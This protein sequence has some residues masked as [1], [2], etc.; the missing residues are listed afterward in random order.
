MSSLTEKT[1]ISA[2]ILG[3]LRQ[4]VSSSLYEAFSLEYSCFLIVYGDEHVFFP[5]FFFPVF[6][7]PVVS[8][9]FSTK[10]IV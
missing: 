8:R 1:D 5:V 4:R 6:F 7:V 9:L 2:T 10:T 3:D